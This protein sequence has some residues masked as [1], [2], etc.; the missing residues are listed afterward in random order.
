LELNQMARFRRTNRRT[1]YEQ[2]F[3][4]N[5]SYAYLSQRK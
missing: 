3:I 2:I 5:W 1:I 4:Q